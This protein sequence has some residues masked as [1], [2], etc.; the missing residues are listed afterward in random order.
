MPRR[1]KLRRSGQRTSDTIDGTLAACR[2]RNE[3]MGSAGL[4]AEPFIFIKIPRTAS[5]S[6]NIEFNDHVLDYIRIGRIP[7]IRQF[8][9]RWRND[10]EL[11]GYSVSYN[12]IPVPLIRSNGLCGEDFRKWRLMFAFVRNPWMRLASLWRFYDNN[13][14]LVQT[15]AVSR[16]RTFDEFVRT[17]YK[18]GMVV[19]VDLSKHMLM[20]DPQWRWL[21]PDIDFVGR[22]EH[23]DADWND[24]CHLLSID[25]PL[26]AR[27]K[28]HRRDGGVKASLAMY[29]V[30]SRRRVARMYRDDVR[31]FGYNEQRTF[32]GDPTP[33]FDRF[34]IIERL[35]EHWNELLPPSH[36]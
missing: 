25:L 31:I 24:L 6:M 17:L 4:R 32:E 7:R 35:K 28:M 18:N 14:L 23:L 26:K 16:C 22:Y 20:S 34:E 9:E 12:H 10:P 19:N 29:N 27:R 15:E 33:K 1:R 13:R 36:T 11:D 5:E 30:V 2:R 8:E 3:M 21:P